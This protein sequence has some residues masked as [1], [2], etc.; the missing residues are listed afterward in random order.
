MPLSRSFDIDIDVK[1]GTERSQFGTRA[2]IYN[3]EDGRVMPHPSGVYLQKVPV[4]KLTGNAAIDYKDGSDMNLLKVD[5]LTNASYDI[6]DSKADLLETMERDPD[7]SLLQRREVVETLPHLSKHFD[8]VKEIAPKS[9]EELA[10]C[11]ALIR[12]G[13]AHL[14][15]EYMSNPKKTRRNLYLRPKEGIYFKRSHAISYAVMI[16]AILCKIE[17]RIIF[18]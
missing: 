5:I 11:L 13:K 10:D 16:A 9:I 8:L 12:P 2:M 15:D 17:T 7:W 18:W 6:F 14:I 4:D 1:S 3:E